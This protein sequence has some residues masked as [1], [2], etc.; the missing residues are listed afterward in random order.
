MKAKKEFKVLSPT[1]IL[2]Y[3]FPAESFQRGVELK[4]DLIAV[5]AGSVDPGPYYLGAGKSFTDRNGV[6][7]DLRFILKAAV[8]LNIPALI[9]SAGGSGA[10]PHVEWC[11]KIIEEIAQE[12]KLSFK[13]GIIYSDIDK[14][15]ILKS[16]AAGRT[17]PLD[18]L[19]P[20]TRETV[21]KAERIVAQMGVE[22]FISAMEQGCQVILGGRAYDPSVFAAPAIVRGYDPGLAV[23]M[24]KILEC[25]A[26]AATPGSGADA[27]MGILREDCFILRPLNPKRKFTQD[28][29]AAHSLYEKAD[30]NFLPGPGGV[31]NLSK[32]VFEEL[33]DG[34][35]KVSGSIFE[36]TPRYAIKLEG[37]EAAGYRTIS[38]AGTRDPIMISKIDSVL[39]N[40]RKQTQDILC[41]E[42]IEGELFFHVYGKDGVMGNLEPKKRSSSHELCIVLEALGKNQAAADSICSIARSTMLHFGYEGRISTAGNLALP[43]SPS[44]ISAGQVF[45]FSIYHLMEID[46]QDVFKIEIVEI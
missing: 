26:I 36:P 7:R 37:V 14:K 8:K 44:D 9:G 10:R 25:A 18:G 4:P 45:V 16:I 30:P 3:G 40:V 13:M 35:V 34:M 42:K 31:L 15:L 20:L 22:P 32:V 5:D 33:P 39:E 11:R 1:A 27:V 6:K 17:S 19:P 24:G 46:S 2:G 29:T 21:E 38:I 23:H 12:E 43:F 28:S 41:S